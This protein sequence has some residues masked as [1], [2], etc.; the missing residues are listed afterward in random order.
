MYVCERTGAFISDN[1]TVASVCPTLVIVKHCRVLSI[2]SI[3]V[4]RTTKDSSAASICSRIGHLIRLRGEGGLSRASTPF[5]SFIFP[6][7]LNRDDLGRPGKL[8]WISPGV[9]SNLSGIRPSYP[10]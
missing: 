6:R 10:T 3:V 4:L 5:P 1:R 8:L 7:S 9:I 2:R